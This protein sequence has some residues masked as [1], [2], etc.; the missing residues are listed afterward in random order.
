MLLLKWDEELKEWTSKIIL[1]LTTTVMKKVQPTR[2]IILKEVH[3]IVTASSPNRNSGSEG[4]QGGT[5][6]G[7][8]TRI[9]RVDFPQFNG[10]D[11]I[12][13][14]YKAEIFLKY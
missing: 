12:E 10:E 5:I 7:V 11:P 6:G 3:P 2:I 1:L 8:Q 9:F 4:T 13:W 14:I